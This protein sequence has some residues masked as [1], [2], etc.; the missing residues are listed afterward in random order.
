MKID[1][2]QIGIYFGILMLGGII[3]FF[4]NS[5]SHQKIDTSTHL[6]IESSVNQIWTCSMHPQIRQSEAGQCPICGMDLIPLDTDS[7]EDNPLEI[8][9]SPTAMQ[10]ASVQ[11][12]VIKKQKPVNEIRLN[13]KVQADERYVSSQTSHIS[14]RIEKLLVNYTGEYISKGQVIAYIYSPEL[15]T[16]QE[17]LFEAYKIRDTQPALYQASREKLKNRKLD[18][19][20]IDGIIKHG[21]PTENFPIRSDL[22]GVV[23]KKRT[24]PGDYINCRNCSRT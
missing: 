5:S 6:H 20:Q 21:S 2:K 9:M 14:G 7:S 22:N 15:V 23:L 18:D 19:S 24:N 10:L 8:K 17:E 13:G 4:I 3:G 11:T 16:A 12:S 1:K